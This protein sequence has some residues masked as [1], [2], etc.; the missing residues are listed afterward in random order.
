MSMC[1]KMKLV[2]DNFKKFQR[3]ACLRVIIN[4]GCIQIK[5][6]TI[7]HLFTATNISNL[8]EQF[9]PIIPTAQIFQTIRIDSKTFDD[10]VT[11]SRGCPNTESCSDMRFYSVTERNNH[12]E[13]VM[14]NIVV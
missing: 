12:I 13:I 14:L 2:L 6:L 7:K 5:H 11:K 9:F 4:G 10:I 3:L 8:I 1:C